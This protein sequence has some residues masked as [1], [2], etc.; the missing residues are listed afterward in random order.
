MLSRRRKV[1][2]SQLDDAYRDADPLPGLPER[3][4]PNSMSRVSVRAVE[5]LFS[6]YMSRSLCLA[7]KRQN[8]STRLV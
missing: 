8:A 4:V 5:R 1:L 7:A 2:V 3:C 6:K